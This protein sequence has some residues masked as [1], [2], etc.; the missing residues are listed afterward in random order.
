MWEGI[1]LT[2]THRCMWSVQINHE[3]WSNILTENLCGYA[4][5]YL[6]K[7]KHKNFIVLRTFH[8]KLENKLST[9]IKIL[10]FK[11][12]EEYLSKKFSNHLRIFGVVSQLTPHGTSKHKWCS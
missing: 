7:H 10:V 12:G 4:Y 6:I 8:N 11:K 3:K 2:S 5:V 9:N 1:R